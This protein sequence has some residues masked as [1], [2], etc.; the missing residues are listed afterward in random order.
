METVLV[1]RGDFAKI[2]L[3]KQ[4]QIVDLMPKKYKGTNTTDISRS[5]FYFRK[6]STIEQ[7][8]QELITKT[9]N[10]QIQESIN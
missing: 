8:L 4:H 3:S 5:V 1:I 9:K 2:L 7:D 10:Q 6:D